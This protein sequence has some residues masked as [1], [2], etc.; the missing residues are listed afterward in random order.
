MVTA[1]LAAGAGI[2]FDLSGGVPPMVSA[3]FWLPFGAAIGF[4][5]ALA[6]E[7]SRNT[8]TSLS[9]FGKHRGYA[10]L[11]AAPELTPRTL[12]QLPPDRRTSLGCLALLPASPFAT[13]FRDLQNTVSK[14]GL[15]AF[16]SSVPNEG[17]STAALCTAIS[18]SQQGRAVVMIDCDLR[19]RSLT[20]A[21]GFD[22][23]EGL[24]DACAAP[25]DWQ[26]YVGEEEE[27]GVH[28]IPAARGGGA[29]RGLSAA[30]GFQELLTRLR[31]HYDLI[32]L[33][34]PPA[35]TSADG[36]T[37]AGLAE[38]TVLVTAW[39]RTPLAAVRRTMSL[40]QR[41]PRTMTGVYINRVPPEYRFGRLRGE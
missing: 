27:I 20:R 21:L 36:L 3:L 29:W 33:D 32:V 14:D 38:K 40:L 19:R 41:R 30:Q 35:L 22:P 2:A 28:F 25:D 8:V 24:L 31:E 6:R 5:I 39:D 37:V 12:R 1:L 18:A 16:I 34:C 10:I 9:S 23:D 11:G 15:V 7:L 13:A 26:N 17:A 4:A